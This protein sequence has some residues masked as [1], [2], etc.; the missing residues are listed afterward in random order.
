MQDKQVEKLIKD[1]EKRQKSV[2]KIS[3]PFNKLVVSEKKSVN[4]INNLTWTYPLHN[5]LKIIPLSGFDNIK[6]YQIK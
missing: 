5:P 6:L 4:H 3:W 1:E 2:I